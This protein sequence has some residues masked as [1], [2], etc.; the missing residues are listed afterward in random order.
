MDIRRLSTVMAVAALDTYMHRLILDRAFSHNI[1]PGGL[2]RLDLPFELLL[3][4]A[5]AP[6]AAARSKPHNTRPRVG[7]KRELRDRLLKDTFQR[8]EDVSR[9]LAMAGRSG[10]WPAIGQQMSPP[11]LPEQIRQ[12]LNEIVMRRNQIVHEGDYRRLERPRDSRRNQMTYGAAM[13][14]IDFMAE[15]VD[16]IHAV[17]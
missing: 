9:A 10:Q 12:R 8:Y 17:V 14:D 4:H 2:A 16:A 15:L 1:M 7:V 3:A 5:D 6:K 11:L 13:V